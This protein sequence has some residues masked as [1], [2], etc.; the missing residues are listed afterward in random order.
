[1]CKVLS[2]LVNGSKL[3][4]ALSQ[5]VSNCWWWAWCSDGVSS[6][7]S[8]GLW[9]HS[10][11]SKFQVQ[12]L[13]CG[14]RSRGLFMLSLNADRPSSLVVAPTLFVTG[15]HWN[16]GIS[17]FGNVPLG[18]RLAEG[19][20]LHGGGAHNTISKKNRKRRGLHQRYRTARRAGFQ[21]TALYLGV[22]HHQIQSLVKRANWFD[23]CIEDTREGS[24]MI[25]CCIARIQCSVCLRTVT[26]SNLASRAVFHDVAIFWSCGALLKVFLRWF[27]DRH[28]GLSLYDENSCVIGDI[29]NKPY[30]GF[31]S[32]LLHRVSVHWCFAYKISSVIWYAMGWYWRRFRLDGKPWAN[33]GRICG[34]HSCVPTVQLDPNYLTMCLFK[35]SGNS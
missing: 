16:G 23:F 30:G 5:T 2:H 35:Y 1:M 13:L 6:L 18:G 14:V 17:E 4:N 3:I 7:F 9:W 21:P 27:S 34:N 11:T 28:S 32:V 29:F 26:A 19:Y 31:P 10:A 20:R 24:K 25:S 8:L 22:S 12:M 33:F 15:E